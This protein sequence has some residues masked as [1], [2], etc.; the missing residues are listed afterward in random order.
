[1]DCEF[2]CKLVSLV[3]FCPPFLR[4]TSLTSLKGFVLLGEVSL[5]KEKI[6]DTLLTFSYLTSTRV[7][8]IYYNFQ[9]NELLLVEATSSLQ[10][11][12]S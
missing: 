5:R 3:N 7:P 11:Y 1:M 8:T 9:V 2:Y 12:I 4:V 10:S 6:C